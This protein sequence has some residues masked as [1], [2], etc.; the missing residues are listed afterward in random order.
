[1]SSSHNEVKESSQLDSEIQI[2]MPQLTIT[3]MTKQKRCKAQSLLPG[4]AKFVSM[5]PLLFL[6]G[7]TCFMDTQATNMALPYM[8]KDFKISESLVQWSLT[9]YYLA[10]ASLSIPLAKLGENIGQVNILLILFVLSTGLNIALFF[11]KNFPAFL[12]L[13]FLSGAVCGGQL[14]CRTSLVRKL[15]PPEKAQAYI[16]YLQILLSIMVIIVPLLAGILIDIQWRWVYIACAASAFLNIF[17][18]IPYTNPE[19]PKE[20]AKFDIWGCIVLFFA[21]GFLDLAFTILSTYHYL[22]CGILVVLSAIFFAIFIFVEKRASDPVLPL[23]LMK[24]PVVSYLVA[25]I[26]SFYIGTGFGY[27]LP[28]TFMFYGHPASQT[29]VI[30]MAAAIGMLTISLFLPKL[31]K[32]FLNK[33]IMVASFSVN[34]FTLVCAIIFSSNVYAFIGIMLIYQIV[35]TFLS[36]LIFPITLLSVPPQFT[37]QMSAVPTTA[38]TLA[39]GVTMC[40]VS[41]IMQV[42]YDSMKTGEGDKRAW[43]NAMRINMIVFLLFQIIGLILLVFRTGYAKNENGKKGFR[44]DKVRQLKIMNGVEENSVLLR[45][46]VEGK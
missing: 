16:Q 40:A 14:V 13:R 3:N 31:S 37:S 1:M 20:K 32:R 38:R 12:V 30:T 23:Q 26:C 36:Q 9:I 5:M 19:T 42:S 43:A 25:N 28:Q 21:I 35:Y 18:L 41:M 22:G 45:E 17:T 7:I 10:Q 8:Q 27:L 6:S 33:Y 39:Q 46:N 29:G 2:Q 44:A 34:V 24:N 11:V 4:Q 15:A